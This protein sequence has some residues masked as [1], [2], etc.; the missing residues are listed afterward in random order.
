MVSAQ[1]M[2]SA[3]HG[4]E[5]DGYIERRPHPFSRRADSWSLTD[6]GLEE[7]ER[8]RQVGSEIF[9]RMLDGFASNEIAAFEDYLRRCILALGGDSVALAD[10]STVERLP[11]RRQNAGVSSTRNV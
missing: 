11:Q 1:T 3:L 9:A 4:L 8:A 5:L 6:A 2:N 7:L 10:P